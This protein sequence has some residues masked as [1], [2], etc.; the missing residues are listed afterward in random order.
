MPSELQQG[1]RPPKGD[2][3]LFS[4]IG[5]KQIRGTGMVNDIQA[6]L[7]MP[8]VDELATSAAERRSGA[9]P[10]AKRIVDVRHL[11]KVFVKRKV[12][13]EASFWSRL[14]M[15][16]RPTETAVAVHDVSFGIDEGEIFGL[17]G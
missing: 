7:D 4:R 2:S 9:R 13:P 15:R 8:A 10:A 1:K 12:D 3:R 5:M 16:G 6:T 14:S 11:R 17:L